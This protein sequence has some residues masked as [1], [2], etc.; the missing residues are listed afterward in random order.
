MKNKF[1]IM[2]FICVLFM[3]VSL[4]AGCNNKGTN[5]TGTPSATPS[6]S[7][8]H[9][10]SEAPQDEYVFKMPI[11]DSLYTITAWRPYTSTYLTSPNEI[12]CNIEL[13][14]RTNIHLDYKLVP[15]ADAVTQY[16]LM[17][18]SGDYTD[19]VFQEIT[20][21]A[22]G[23]DKAISD[24]VFIELSDVVNKWMPNLKNYMDQNDDIRKQFHTDAGN[25]GA[26]INIQNGNQPAWIGPGIRKDFLEKVGISELPQTYDD[27]YLALSKF[28][29]ELAV[30][31]PL[32]IY[33]K[34]YNVTSH[35]MT[36]GFDVAPTF[37]NEN[38]TVKFG[39][40]EEGFRDYLT[41]MNKWYTEGLIDK[42]FYTRS[43]D[44]TV[45]QENM[46]SG[47]VGALEH[48]VY[49][50]PHIY[51]SLSGSDEFHLVAMPLP[52]KNAGDVA[53]FRRVNEITG[54][55]VIAI[56][57][58]V[59]DA[60]RLENIARWIDYRFSDEGALLLNYGIEGE[61]YTLKDGE[62]VFTDYVLHNSDGISPADILGQ[63]SDSGFA[64]IYDWTREKQMVSEEEWAAYDIWGNSASGDWVMP[65]VTMTSEE[66]S[67]YAT[68]FGDIDTLITETIPLF[69]TGAKPMTEYGQ[70][71]DQ[72]KSMNID[73][74]IDIQ[75][76]ALDRYMN[77]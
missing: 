37:Y 3:A 28:K 1:R 44:F 49:T 52:R 42:D 64:A 62:P 22:G 55:T 39:F 13:E 6:Q 71:I 34:G 24:G 21:Y 20:Q 59:T 50:L 77:R 66:G 47:K 27:L 70:F 69:I 29:N 57:T 14:K 45:N 61:T 5:T 38:G 10:Q 46:V 43:T 51:K 33:Y 12:L 18:T 2:T 74:C 23:F 7:E 31:Q 73:R 26:I 19:I 53:H 54:T 16:N 56:T 76:A 30:E 8:G 35:T 60:D 40:I 9:V 72:L 32:S 65:P 36:A 63:I 67:E 11:A 58:A 4:L 48:M 68:I 15:Q 25:I 75:Q 17:I 41:M